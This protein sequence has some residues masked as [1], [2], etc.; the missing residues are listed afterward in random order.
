MTNEFVKNFVSKLIKNPSF[1]FGMRVYSP[2]REER[3]EKTNLC[4]CPLSNRF[5]RWKKLY[6]IVDIDNRNIFCNCDRYTSPHGLMQHLKEKKRHCI[7]HDIVYNYLYSL[8]NTWWSLDIGNDDEY[9]QHYCLI[10]NQN[11]WDARNWSHRQ[12]HTLRT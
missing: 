4:Y 12:C 7:Y 5:N 2:H 3:K 9:S 1:D 10:E 11:S 8:Y 6:D